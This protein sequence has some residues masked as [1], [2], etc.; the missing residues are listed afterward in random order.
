[1]D[2]SQNKDMTGFAD[3]H[4]GTL[5]VI[6]VVLSFYSVDSVVKM[7]QLETE[8]NPANQ[9]ALETN[10]LFKDISVNSERMTGLIKSYLSKV[11]DQTP[12]ETSREK[13]LSLLEVRNLTLLNYILDI[14]CLCMEK[15]RGKSIEGN[16][17]IDRLVELRTAIEKMKP[18]HYKLKYRIEKLVRAANS[19]TIDPNDPINF[20][21]R[22][23]ELIVK[24]DVDQ[25]EQMSE[26]DQTAKKK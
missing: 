3:K 23:D 9:M 8:S 21:P 17:A 12:E 5:L 13:G 1:M 18:I 22:L 16:P 20:R 6:H 19:Q 15:I 26:D 14:G 2:K 24:E 7:S 10:D 4:Q 25:S 11:K